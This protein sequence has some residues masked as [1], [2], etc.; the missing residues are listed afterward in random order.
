LYVVPTL[1]PTYLNARADECVAIARGRE[2]R[3]VQCRGGLY[4]VIGYY[5]ASHGGERVLCYVLRAPSK[6][7]GSRRRT[8]NG[9]LY[10]PAGDDHEH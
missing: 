2:E 5:L 8:N 3:T 4:T 10:T 6:T 1:V 9:A 7:D